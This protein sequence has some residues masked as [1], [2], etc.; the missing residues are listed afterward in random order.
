M[1]RDL[2]VDADDASRLRG[3]EGLREIA[4]AARDVED[5]ILR[6]DPAR[7]HRRPAPR[8]IASEGVQT[9][10]EIGPMR[11]GVEHRAD[12]PRLVLVAMRFLREIRVRPRRA[13]CLGGGHGSAESSPHYS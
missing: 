2:D 13:S 5:A 4:R 6:S 9:V 7:P 8:L 12:A 1:V 10:V 3:R 11:D